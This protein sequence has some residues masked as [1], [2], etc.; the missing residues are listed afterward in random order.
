MI[1]LPVVATICV[2]SV[3]S[4]PVTTKLPD[5]STAYVDSDVSVP[6]II[7]LPLDCLSFPFVDVPD[8]IRLPLVS[9][10]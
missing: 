1:K 7:K 5:V 10:A 9:T 3:V 4:V 6:L 8:M 2:D